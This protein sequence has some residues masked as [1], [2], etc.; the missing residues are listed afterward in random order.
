MT[1]KYGADERA[2]V[3]ARATISTIGRRETGQLRLRLQLAEV[4]RI[5]QRIE[6]SPTFA[7]AFRLV[8]GRNGIPVTRKGGRAHI[9]LLRYFG[10]ECPGGTLARH[11][12]TV[13]RLVASGASGHE[14]RESMTNVGPTKLLARRKVARR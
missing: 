9:R 12:A 4:A 3:I 1:S 6:D 2:I 8:A 13:A 11:A 5:A 10:F 7:I 14:I